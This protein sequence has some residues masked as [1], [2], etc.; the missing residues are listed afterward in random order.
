VFAEFK[1][2]FELVVG[3]LQRVDFGLESLQSFVI[4]CFDFAF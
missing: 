1:F 2:D 4:L 3:F